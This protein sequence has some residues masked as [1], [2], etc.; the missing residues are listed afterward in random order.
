MELS[1]LLDELI[2]K[3]F[4]IFCPVVLLP[5]LALALSARPEKPRLPPP[6]F[7]VEEA[8]GML[9]MDACRLA[10]RA[11]IRSEGRMRTPMKLLGFGTSGSGLKNIVRWNAP[12]EAR[13]D[14]RQRDSLCGGCL[15]IHLL[16]FGYAAG[17]GRF[18]PFKAG[19]L[20]TFALDYVSNHM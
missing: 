6:S 1:F 8:C 17:D 2:R 4:L 10:V 11:V 16:Q 9:S 7:S 14:R 19:G 15:R 12:H 18:P 20:F 13:L 5:T 3:K